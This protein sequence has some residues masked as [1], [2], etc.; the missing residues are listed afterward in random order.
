MNYDL[1]ISELTNKIIRIKGV[2]VVWLI[3]CRDSIGLVNKK[4][5]FESKVLGKKKK[6]VA[7]TG[8]EVTVVF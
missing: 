7:G 5:E 6:I 3:T 1:T 2:G 4:M 8:F